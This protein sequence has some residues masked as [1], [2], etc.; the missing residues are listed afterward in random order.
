MQ[1]GRVGRGGVQ[2]CTYLHTYSIQVDEEDEEES[3]LHE[4]VAV[5][6]QLELKVHACMPY[7]PRTHA[8]H[9]THARMHACT[10]ARMH[11]SMIANARM[12]ACAH[13]HVY[14]CTH[15]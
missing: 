6:R 7:H 12:D 5:A 1:G 8:Y 11:T 13:T 4:A 15:A 3:T 14:A 10:C 2:N 9:T